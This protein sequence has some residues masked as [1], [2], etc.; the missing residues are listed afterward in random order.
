MS[1]EKTPYKVVPQLGRLRDEVVYDDVWEQSELSKR[2]RSLITIS[3]LIALYRTPELRG[4]FALRLQERREV[5]GRGSGDGAAREGLL[6][7]GDRG[8]LLGAEL[9][10]GLEVG[11]LLR[12]GRLQVGE[13]LRVGVP[14]VRGVR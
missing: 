6:R 2:D 13:V 10:P 7:V 3:A 5:R 1:G 8:D 14:G 4:H 9:L 11:G 12:A